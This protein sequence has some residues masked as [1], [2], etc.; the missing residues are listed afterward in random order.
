MSALMIPLTRGLVALVDEQ[1]YELVRGYKWQA[2]PDGHTFYVGRGVREAGEQRTVQLH[3][4]LTGWPLVDHRN[5][6]GL[7]NR[8][9]NLR[10][11]TKSQNCANRPIRTAN[12]SGFKGVDLRK[13]RWRAQIKSGDA[14]VHLGY[15]DLAEEAARA[16]DAAAIEVF[17]EFATLNFPGPGQRSAISGDFR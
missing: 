8:R 10:Q 13:D 9:A 11:A 12:K 17:G 15:F 16:Y 14:K 1:D 7:D 4:F 5:G 6:D 3:N 2:R